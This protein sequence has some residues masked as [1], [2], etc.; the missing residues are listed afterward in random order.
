LH[1][2]IGDGPDDKDLLEGSFLFT[3]TVADA[4]GLDRFEFKDSLERY[5]VGLFDSC[6]AHN[7]R[8]LVR[9]LTPVWRSR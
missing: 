9:D 7:R 6:A 3:D 4:F 1:T 2:V 5:V 8:W